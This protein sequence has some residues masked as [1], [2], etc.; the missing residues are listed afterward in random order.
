M[1]ENKFLVPFAIVVAGGLIAGAIY[2]GAGTS[3]T[4]VPGQSTSQTFKIAPVTEKDHYR[5]SRSA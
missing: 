1:Q 3:A 4:Y 5:G 2:F